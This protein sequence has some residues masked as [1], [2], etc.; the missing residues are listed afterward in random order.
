VIGIVI[1]AHGGLAREYLAA[2]EHVVGPA[3][4]T[5]AVSIEANDDC[6]S[7]QAEVDAAVDAVDEGQGVIVVTDMF[8]STPSNLAMIA[9][10][11]T[12]NR[13]VVYGANLP[14]LVKLAKARHKPLNDA[15]A[16]ALTAGRKYINC[17]DGFGPNGTP[18]AL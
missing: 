3:P 17:I 16:C 9:C 1:V 8:G 5:A 6:G 14:M 2:M 11:R 7:K 13:R 15:V 18:I 10:R 12:A 4:G